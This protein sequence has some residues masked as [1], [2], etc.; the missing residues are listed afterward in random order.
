[1]QTA[2][3]RVL[4]SYGRGQKDAYAISKNLRLSVVEVRRI[5]GENVPTLGETRTQGARPT[6]K[7]KRAIKVR[8]LEEFRNSHDYKHIISQKLS[9]TF[10]P[11]DN[12]GYLLDHEMREVCAIPS[13]SWRRESE[14]FLDW[15]FKLRDK[16][17]WA[18]PQTIIKMK[19]ITG[20]IV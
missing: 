2:A 16:R 7:T 20:R 3:K 17:Y 15:Q 10:P 12:D 11:S 19:K 18:N 9:E 6:G 14:C 5:L 13:T 4:A 1:M 8:P